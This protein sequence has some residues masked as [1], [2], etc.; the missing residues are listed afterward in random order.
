MYVFLTPPSQ[1]SDYKNARSRGTKVL[2]VCEQT[3][4]LWDIWYKQ[5]RCPAPGGRAGLF[6]TNTV[7]NKPDLGELFTKFFQRLNYQLTTTSTRKAVATLVGFYGSSEESKMKS[8]LSITSL[9]HS[10]E[11]AAAIANS[12]SR[13]TAEYSYNLAENRDALY[14]TL[15]FLNRVSH[16]LRSCRS[17]DR[18]ALINWRM[19]RP[20]QERG[21]DM[22]LNTK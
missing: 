21:N 9:T 14:I 12:H 20:F 19:W 3:R 4:E 8:I 7:G 22:I 2:T 15:G 13:E 18:H 6:F 10:A 16:S 17:S 5:I 1:I 11:E